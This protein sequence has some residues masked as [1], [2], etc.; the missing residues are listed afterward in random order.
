MIRPA[1]S[2]CTKKQPKMRISLISIRAGNWC[3]RQWAPQDPVKPP[4]STVWYSSMTPDQ[5]VRAGTVVAPAG[6]IATTTTT[7][8]RR[9][10]AVGKAWQLCAGRGSRVLLCRP[11]ERKTV[12]KYSSHRKRSRGGGGGHL[13]R[14]CSYVP[15][16]SQNASIVSS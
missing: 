13:Q 11:H 6:Y 14:S 10:I 3:G 16:V 4:R 5:I 8:E 7:S 1:R 12:S 15:H 9:A 2:A